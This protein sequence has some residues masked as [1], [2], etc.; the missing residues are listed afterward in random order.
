MAKISNLYACAALVAA[1]LSYGLLRM[2]LH[3]SLEQIRYKPAGAATARDG[4]STP[5]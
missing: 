2:P 5:Y 1:S 4:I 3:D